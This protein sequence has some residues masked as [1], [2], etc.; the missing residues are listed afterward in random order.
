MNLYYSL[1]T[2]DADTDFLKTI[3]SLA[4]VYI[5]ICVRAIENQISILHTQTED[6]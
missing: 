5:I 3:Y 6:D 4:A 1:I 2:R